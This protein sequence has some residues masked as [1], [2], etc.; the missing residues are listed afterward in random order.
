MAL[1]AALQ[2]RAA[3]GHALIERDVVADDSGAAD[4]DAH[5]VIDEQAAADYRTGMDF[6]AG[7]EASDM[8][9]EAAD[10]F[11]PAAPQEMREAVQDDGVETGVAQ[12]D[13]EPRARGRVMRHD[14]ADVFR[15]PR[16]HG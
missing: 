6:D 5:A 13:F 15:H 2:R 8:G 16:E 1:H 12:H 10:Q 3:Q 4:D 7:E 14:R 11:K 9:H